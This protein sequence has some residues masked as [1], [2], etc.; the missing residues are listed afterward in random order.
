MNYSVTFFDE[1]QMPTEEPIDF[2]A[3]DSGTLWD[4]V[5]AALIADSTDKE[6]SMDEI[7]SHLEECNWRV[8]EVPDMHRKTI[9]AL[10][11]PYRGWFE[12]CYIEQEK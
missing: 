1:D 6:L 5:K 9:V 3:D 10:F 7:Q 11:V 2:S 12:M 8:W 4:I